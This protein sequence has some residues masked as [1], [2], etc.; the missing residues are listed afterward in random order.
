M[1]DIGEIVEI[2]QGVLNNIEAVQSHITEGVLASDS[3]QGGVMIANASGSSATLTEILGV[4]VEAKRLLEE[5]R[6]AYQE[7]TDRINVYLGTI[8]G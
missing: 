8:Q 7:A 4:L 1:A 3:A 6:G 5:P 2:L